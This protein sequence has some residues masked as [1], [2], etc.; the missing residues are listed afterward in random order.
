LIPHAAG[1]CFYCGDAGLTSLPGEAVASP[2][3]NAGEQTWRPE[4]LPAPSSAVLGND[5]ADS[6]IVRALL[7]LRELILKGEFSPGTRVSEAPLTSR[8][9][10]SR[11]PVRLALERLAHEGLL[12]PYPTGGFVVRRFTLDDVWDGIEVRGVLEGAAA[13]LAA[14]RLHHDA[15]VDR[16]RAIQHDM[17]ALREPTPDTFPAYLDLNDQFHMEVLRLSRSAMVRQ[18]LDRL[19]SIPLASRSALVSLQIRFPEASEVFIV[20][21]DQHVRIIEAISRR[22]GTRAEAIAREHAQITRRALEFAVAHS[23]A[24]S[25][26]PGGPLIQGVASRAT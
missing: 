5:A 9:G 12:E 20:G 10:V 8:L 3:G 21:R 1:A 4:P 7:N 2:S 22:Q 19:L 17:D 24:L 15:D 25:V 16:L 14:E 6:Q 13:R 26:L 18:A 23:D 11:T